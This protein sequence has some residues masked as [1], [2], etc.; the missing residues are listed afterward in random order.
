MPENAA[1][2]DSHPATT[3]STVHI[4]ARSMRRSL[5]AATTAASWTPAPSGAPIP[6]PRSGETRRARIWR[7]PGMG[8]HSGGDDLVD[9]LVG[10][11]FLAFVLIVSLAVIGNQV[12]SALHHA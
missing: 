4:R 8:K 5:R 6:V 3:T 11:M 7:S 12:A 9:Y 10:V 1:G 2:R